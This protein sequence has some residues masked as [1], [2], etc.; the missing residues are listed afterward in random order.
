MKPNSQEGVQLFLLLFYIGTIYHELFSF[1]KKLY[2]GP[3]IVKRFFL[4]FICRNVDKHNFLQER[5]YTTSD[6]HSWK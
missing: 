3:K 2:H 4:S 5:Q 1:A 6:Y